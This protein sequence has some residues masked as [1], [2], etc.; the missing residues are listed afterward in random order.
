MVYEDT[1][2][3]SHSTMRTIAMVMSIVGP[4]GQKV[5]TAGHLHADAR[6][7]AWTASRGGRTIA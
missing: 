2:P 3:S 5:K 4:S 7:V 1:I 6:M